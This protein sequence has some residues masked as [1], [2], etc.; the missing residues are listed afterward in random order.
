MK[1]PLS[2]RL[3]RALELERCGVTPKQA[4]ALLGVTSSAMRMR[5]KRARAISAVARKPIQHIAL[6][7]APL[8]DIH[9][10]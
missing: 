6:H 4:A 7:P 10:I 8:A 2:M 5:L 9:N 1:S 3:R